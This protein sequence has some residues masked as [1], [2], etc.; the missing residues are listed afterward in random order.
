MDEGQLFALA[1]KGDVDAQAQLSALALQTVDYGVPKREA[2]CGAEILCRMAASQGRVRDR[3]TL[4]GVLMLRAADI[5]EAGDLERARRLEA[6][7]LDLLSDLA[8]EGNQ[9]AAACLVMAL[10]EMADNG[11][12]MAAVRLNLL[13]EKISPEALALAGRMIGAS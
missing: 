9:E 8:S 13:V 2:L 5:R 10:D 1:A 7:G 4:C 3:M 11:D 6:E 12:E